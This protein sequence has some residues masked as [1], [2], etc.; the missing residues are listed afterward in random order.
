MKKK[1]TS[2]VLDDNQLNCRKNKNMEEQLENE[3]FWDSRVSRGGKLNELF[4][5]I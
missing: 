2:F 1:Y 3:Q 5:I 4:L